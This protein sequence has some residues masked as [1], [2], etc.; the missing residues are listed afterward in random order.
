MTSTVNEQ[1]RFKDPG[2]RR[3]T[4]FWVIGAVLV[5][6]AV[7][8]IAL[9]RGGAEDRGATDKAEQLQQALEDAGLT[10]PDTDQITAVL[11]SDGGAMCED[12]AAALQR[13]LAGGTAG[14]GSRTVFVGRDWV[15]A[16]TLAIQVYC[17]DELPEFLEY[18][19][20]LDLTDLVKE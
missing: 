16:E 14:P 1:G 7:V 17:P 12:P 20:G 9:Y 2:R 3:R 4:T 11:G 5:V 15:T 18:V 10:A 19:N 6:L 8:G 13:A